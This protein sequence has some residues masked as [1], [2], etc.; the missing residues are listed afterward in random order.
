MNAAQAEESTDVIM[1]N[2]PVNDFP[3]KV[4][5]DTGASHCFISR[6]FTS[7]HELTS[8]LLPSPLAVVSPGKRMHANS[9]VPDVSITLGDYKFLASPTVPG[10]SD[11]DLILGMD[12]LSK[13]KAQL[14]CAA[15]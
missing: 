11:I 10:D 9:I 14:D 6:P 3:A 13:N 8:Q 2:L 7:S 5:F 15:R 4:L 12:W 1:G